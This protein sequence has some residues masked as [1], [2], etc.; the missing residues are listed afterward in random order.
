MPVVNVSSATLRVDGA[1]EVGSDDLAVG[2]LAAEE[3]LSRGFDQLAY[4]APQ[5]TRYARQRGEGFAQ[6][7]AEAGTGIEVST[8]RSQEAGGLHDWL[9]NL[10]GPVG[11]LASTDS[12]GRQAIEACVAMGRRVPEDVAVVGVDNDTQVCDLTYP[13]MS[14]VELPTH[15]IGYR[16]CELLERMIRGEAPPSEPV[17]VPPRRLVRR[18]SSDIY[19]VPDPTV[20]QAL[21]II[22][23]RAASGVSVEDVLDGLEVSRRSL[24]LLFRKHLGRSPKAELRRV[25]IEKARTLLT[26]TLMPMSEVASRCGFAGQVRF[27]MVFKEVTGQT[28]TAYRQQRN[29]R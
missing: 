7:A 4:Y 12:A 22:R 6:A 21:R 23:E 8:Y 10:P 2:R 18:Q 16:A 14:S 29:P 20:R 24:E 11:L 1:A 15:T 17:R 26:E 27:A 19:A 28:P 13:P 9:N 25:Q 5:D 3:F